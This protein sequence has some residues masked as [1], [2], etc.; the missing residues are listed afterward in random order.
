MKTNKLYLIAALLGTTLA[1]CQKEAEMQNPEERQDVGKT[2]TLTIKASKGPKTRALELVTEDGKTSLDAKWN[3][4]EKVAVYDGGILL[5]TLTVTEVDADGI[6]TL[7]G[8]LSL[9]DV[10]TL[11]LIYPGREDQK[12]TYLGQGGDAPSL[13][14]ALNQFDYATATVSTDALALES[15]TSYAATTDV[16]DFEN[17][18]S[19]YCFGFK[20][21]GNPLTAAKSI[22]LSS[23]NG[24]VRSRTNADGNWVSETGVIT[25]T[26]TVS[27][28]EY[29]MSVRNENTSSDVYTFNVVGSDNALY[30]GTK[31]IPASALAEMGKYLSA[32]SIA[33][34]KKTFA[35]EE[36]G[37][38]SADSDVL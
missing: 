6:A 27:G 13:T 4:G 5:G 23:A 25:V 1:S 36:S 3:Q 22:L 9:D 26:P 2:W 31:S 30:S 10:N 24:L 32:R 34:A 38:V 14:G 21:S 28:A 29:Y 16:I 20:D 11:T 37:S 19:I 7:S 18:Q 33:V 12:W 8:S 35:P 17:E 15:E